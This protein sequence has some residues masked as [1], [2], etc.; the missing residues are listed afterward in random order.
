LARRVGRTHSPIPIR[1]PPKT[2]LTPD[3]LVHEVTHVWQ[4]QTQCS[5]YISDSGWHQLTEGDDAYC[6]KLASGKSIY[7]YTAEQQAVIVEGY[8]TDK[9]RNPQNAATITEFCPSNQ[10]VP[11][12]WSKLPDVLNMIEEVRRARPMSDNDN[13]QERLFGPGWNACDTAPP[14]GRRERME[15]LPILRIEFN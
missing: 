7:S 8:Y 13:L 3:V 9:M 11:S 15:V 10:V 6:V 1:I 4:F 12:G 2:Q 5:A 14:A